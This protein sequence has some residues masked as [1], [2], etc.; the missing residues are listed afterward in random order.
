MIEPTNAGAM[1]PPV[2][3]NTAGPLMKRFQ[4]SASNALD[5]HRADEDHEQPDRDAAPRR[6]RRR[7]RG[8]SCAAAAASARSPGA[9]LRLHQRSPA[10]WRS[11]R[12]TMTLR[13]EVRDER[14][15][16]QDQRRGR[17]ARRARWPSGR[18]GSCSRA[19]S[20][21][22]SRSREREVERLQAVAD[23]LGDRDRLAER[24]AEPERDRRDDPALDVGDDHASH[25]LPSRCAEPDRGLLHVPRD[26][27]EELLADRRGDR[28]H[29]HRQDDD[30]DQHAGLLR[31]AG[32]ERA[33]SRGTT[34]GTARS[35]CA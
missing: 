20:R 3:P 12:W 15:H 2:S 7:S 35:R 32:E 30:R 9:R 19:G 33:S 27:D 4:L 1:P 5:E 28:D 8:R 10:R 26:V 11:K 17:R 13:R 24:P 25:R 31:R 23:H 16:E 18:S 29:H 22:C 14:D 6:S 34:G 21:G